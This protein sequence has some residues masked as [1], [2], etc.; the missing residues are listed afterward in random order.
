MRGST[1]SG[2]II[3]FF[4]APLLAAAQ[5][6]NGTI[7]NIASALRARQY[8][9]SLQLLDPALR[10][11]PRD[12][13]LWTM[14]G[15][16]LSGLQ[17]S[18][19]SL[20]AYRHAIKL[21]PD[22]LPALE[23]AAQLEY[24]RGDKD[25][26]PILQHI[27]KLRPDNP[28][29]H[30]MLAVLFY[31]QG[32]CSGAT[33]HFA[34]SNPILDSQPAAL[35]QYGSCLVTLHQL[36]Q[37]LGVF[38]RLLDLNPDDSHNRSRLA[39]V[40]LTADHPKEAIATLQPLLQGQPEIHV[41]ELAA[42]AFEAD[43]DTPQAES[44]LKKAMLLDPGN[45]DL[46]VDFAGLAFDHQS[47]A[48]GIEMMTSGLRAHPDAAPL[49]LE[50]GILYVQLAEYENAEADFEKASQLDP[51]QSLVGV[52]QSKVAEQNG[53]FDGALATVQR[54]LAKNPDDSFLLYTRADILVQ[55]GVEP[56]TREFQLAL[57]SAGR[58]VVLQPR[59]VLAHDIL[60]S[61]YLQAGQYQL[62]IEQS[63]RA[64]EY[65][66]KDQSALYHLIIAQRKTGSSKELPDLLK[67]L[68]QLRQEATKEASYRNRDRQTSEPLK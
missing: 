5:A 58:A 57:Q 21:S 18:T 25:I 13:R 10:Q 6:D 41:F 26:V 7:Q 66:S 27:L 59:L 65:D 24:E 16:A 35:Q 47:F 23:G 53:D 44:T 32:D 30:A 40:Q 38:Q 54:E 67:R 63:R 4:L 14:Q 33:R 22:Y 15:V 62:S 8:E 11:F 45:V 36:D 20:V 31:K 46:Y 56:G 61:L 17:R 12:V 37:A 68:A 64:L 1:T 52:A 9:D 39:E 43:G 2:A 60:G 48:S 29:S 51:H 28:N 3:L 19:E 49:Y 55:K 50:R 42:A 34:L